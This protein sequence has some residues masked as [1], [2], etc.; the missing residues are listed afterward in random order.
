L[1]VHAVAEAGAVDVGGDV[2]G[3][4]C[5]FWSSTQFQDPVTRGLVVTCRR[6]SAATLSVIG[7]SKCATTTMPT[8]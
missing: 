8:P 5:A 1:A 3:R 6:L 4:Q 2:D 7:S